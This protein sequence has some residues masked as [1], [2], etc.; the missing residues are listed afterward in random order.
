MRQARE[1]KTQQGAPTS[2]SESMQAPVKGWNTRD[3]ISNMDPGFATK[4]ENWFPQTN[5]IRVRKGNSQHLTGLGGAVETLMCYNQGDGT[6]TL[7]AA[8]GTDFYD[9]TSAGAAGAAV[10]SGLTN[11]RWNYENFTNSGG[12]SYLMA[13]NGVDSPQYWNGSAW[14]A[15]TGVSSPAI[16]GVTPTNLKFPIVHKR[17]VFLIEK[18]SLK[19][20]YL[21]IDAVG[22]AAQAFDLS[23]IANKGGYLVAGAT[24]TIDGGEG[25]DDHLALMTSEGQILVYSGTN[26]ASNYVL[27]G[28]WNLGEPLTERCMYKYKGDVLLLL[29]EGLLPL[30]SALQAAGGDPSAAFTFNIQPTFN[31]AARNY[32][33]NFGWQ[34]I[35]YP[36]GNMIIANIPVLEGS[37]QEQYAM[38]TITGAWC[39]FTN[40]DA[41]CWGICGGDIYFGKEGGV[42]KFWDTEADVSANIDADIRHAFSYFNAPAQIKNLNALRPNILSNGAPT[43]KVG[44]NTDFQDQNVIGSLSYAGS[45]FGL[46]GNNWGSMVWGGDLNFF[47]QWVTAPGVGTAIAPR[48]KL[49]TSGLEVRYAAMD[50]LY[51]SGTPIG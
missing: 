26:P 5:D 6:Q 51:E 8:E 37:N 12:T 44:V 24:W 2:L 9:A 31:E 16:T 21:P 3:P 19:L 4:L 33:T 50:I 18:D 17:R 36:A 40:I 35:H 7:F 15:I 38:N 28:V 11:A 20:W 47:G 27:V 45:A 13:F 32:A 42:N 30:S 14:I 41:S 46:W 10:V 23:G 22:G 48:I 39:R 43:L 49:S 25:M 34:V 1:P 29:K